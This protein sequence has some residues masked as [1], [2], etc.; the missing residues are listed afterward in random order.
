MRVVLFVK[1]PERGLSQLDDR[2]W[3]SAMIAS[4]EHVNYLTLHGQE[5]QTLEGKLNLDAGQLE[6]LVVR[7]NNKT[8]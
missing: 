3:D 8:L 1:D 6:L 7:M 2:E 4:L 5:Y